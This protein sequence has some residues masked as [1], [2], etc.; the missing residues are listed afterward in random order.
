M[1]AVT[2]AWTAVAKLRGKVQTQAGFWVAAREAFWIALEELRNHKLRSFLT[3]L[4]VVIATTTLIVVMSVVNG[5]NYYIATKIAN[6]GANTF[7]V[8]QFRWAQS[9]DYY[10]KALRRNRPIRLEDYE[11]L[12]D[13]LSGYEAMSAIEP[14]QPQ[15]EARYA[16]HSIDEV[17]LVGVTAS[18]AYIGRE[19][20]SYGRYISE[21]DYRHSSKVCF[22]GQDIVDKLFP[23]VD[24]IGKEIVVGGQSFS[25]IGVAEKVGSAF[26][27][28]QDNFIMVPLGAFR[29]AFMPH[30]ELLIF[31]KAPDSQHL[32]ELQ[33]EVRV[34]MRARRHVPYHDEDN[35]GI[36]AAETLMSAW[37]SLTG[38]I[39]AVTIGVVAVFMV[40]GGIV[41]MNIML[42]TVTERTHEIGIRKSVGARRG[43]IMWQFLIEAGALAGIGGATGVLI[44]FG[45]SE[46]INIFFTAK[47]PISAVIVGVALSTGVGLFFGI[48]PA[49]RAARLDPIQALRAEK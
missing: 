36:N 27:M 8:H 31:I 6:L 39:F 23:S 9:Y 3:L 26:G 41:I 45:F 15:P 13:T 12:R 21:Q 40:V 19:K 7:V 2:Q 25:V 44:A 22:V 38:P 47:V 29:N 33:D 49:S 28:S 37:Q 34:A 24:P 5:M 46:L 48:Y 10:L 11:Y 17:N 20:V 30:L 18:H 4:G 32:A 43:D 35:F 16:G 1:A 14:L 42:A